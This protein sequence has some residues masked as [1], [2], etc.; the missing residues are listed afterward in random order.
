[1]L[2]RKIDFDHLLQQKGKDPATSGVFPFFIETCASFSYA[3]LRHAP[4][5]DFFPTILPSPSHPIESSPHF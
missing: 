5:L 2:R 1:M 3:P 4:F